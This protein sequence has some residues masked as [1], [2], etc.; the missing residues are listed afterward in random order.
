MLSLLLFQHLVIAPPTNSS[1]ERTMPPD[2]TASLSLVDCQKVEIEA[3][4]LNLL[5]MLTNLTVH[6][7]ESL[8]LRSRMYDARRGTGI[9]KMMKVIE[10]S[11][12]R[13]NYVQFH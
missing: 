10:F 11:N 7:T 6:N 5:P 2:V 8:T 9:S 12:V 4:T 1:S 13:A 3:Q